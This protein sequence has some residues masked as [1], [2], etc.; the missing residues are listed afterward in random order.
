MPADLFTCEAELKV[1][2]LL[3]EITNLDEHREI[4]NQV[5][6][7]I[8]DNGSV[9]F[10][11]PLFGQTTLDLELQRPSSRNL[12]VKVLIR[13]EFDIR[14]ADV[15]PDPN[16]P[17]AEPRQDLL[18]TATGMAFNEVVDRLR[19]AVALAS[20]GTAFAE[21]TLIEP[22]I[23]NVMPVTLHGSVDHAL[24]SAAV[25]FEGAIDRGWPPVAVMSFSQAAEWI[26]GFEGLV[27]G[28][29]TS[30]IERA[31]LC[32]DHAMVST[33]PM[34]FF[35]CITGL[36]ALFVQGAGVLD[37]LRRNLFALIGEPRSHKKMFSNMYDQRSKLIHGAMNI[38]SAELERSLANESITEVVGQASETAAIVLVSSLQELC[39]RGWT[40]LNFGTVV[41]EAP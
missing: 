39:T 7:P 34:A 9:R 20:G 35:W 36:E 29:S 32:L 22:S 14:R 26:L 31:V 4:V 40:S 17:S 41:S 28:R 13:G 12:P 6:D 3:A 21:R 30:P 8:A 5:L 38:C 37:P 27:L 24:H 11:H 2:S 10:V 15:G 33:E 18:L 1:A 19:D 25:G 23:R 16:D